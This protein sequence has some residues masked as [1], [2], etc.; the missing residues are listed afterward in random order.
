MAEVGVEHQF[1][2]AAVSALDD[3][4]TPFLALDLT[5]LDRN[6]ER[7]RSELGRLGGPTLRPHFKSHKSHG[8]RVVRSTPARSA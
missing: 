7:M 1:D 4:T 3:V 5:L 6:L 2:E 8:S